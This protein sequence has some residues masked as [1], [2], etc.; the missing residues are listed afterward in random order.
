MKTMK[1]IKLLAAASVLLT[2][3]ACSGSDSNKHKDSGDA[4]SC[5]SGLQK[6]LNTFVVHWRGAEKENN[7]GNT[8][9]AIKHLYSL[10]AVCEKVQR[11]NYEFGCNMKIE[12][13]LETIQADVFNERCTRVDDTIEQLKRIGVEPPPSEEVEPDQPVAGGECNASLKKD[14][15]QFLDGYQQGERY[16]KQKNKPQLI[17]WVRILAKQCADILVKHQ[18][19]EFGCKMTYSGKTD[20]VK[21]DEFSSLCDQGRQ[22]VEDIDNG[23][24]E[25]DF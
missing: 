15:T 8:A 11:S 14:M 16:R 2:I 10:K 5:S 17:Q 1:T 7:S 19:S 3:A 12:G 23:T 20:T 24:A 9:A 22:A 25:F 18:P 13:K 21:W 4:G 6:E